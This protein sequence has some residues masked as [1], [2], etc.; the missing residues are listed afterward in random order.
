MSDPTTPASP[1][2]DL[3]IARTDGKTVERF[4]GHRP[5]VEFEKAML[6]R[7]PLLSDMFR[8]MHEARSKMIALEAELKRRF[9]KDVS[10]TN[11]SPEQ[12]DLED[13]IASLG[14]ASEDAAV[15]IVMILQ[16]LL[17][18][19]GRALD[20]DARDLGDE[21][22][23]GYKFSRVIW[24]LANRVRHVSEWKKNGVDAQAKRSIQVIDALG[25]DPMSDADVT[26]EALIACGFKSY[27]DLKQRTFSV[28]KAVMASSGIDY[29]VSP[30]GYSMHVKIR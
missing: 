29:K 24:A 13:E 16:S 7:E 10:Y 28:S 27:E 19:L 5:A 23:P 6:A 11:T 1:P 20:K 8:N 4:P 22:M 9:S 2:R 26:Y 18:A 17:A 15:S 3:I 30:S 12:R 14:A 21:V 25:L